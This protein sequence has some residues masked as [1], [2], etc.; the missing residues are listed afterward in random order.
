MKEALALFKVVSIFELDELLVLLATIISE[1]KNGK[2]SVA[3]ASSSRALTLSA[4]RVDALP[5]EDDCH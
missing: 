2:V 3:R 1:I 4:V 5:A